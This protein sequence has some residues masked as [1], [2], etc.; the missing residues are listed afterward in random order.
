MNDTLSEEY[1]II[2]AVGKT[3]LPVNLN[4]T[5][6]EES[7][8]SPTSAEPVVSTEVSHSDLTQIYIL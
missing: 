5:R 7:N 4:D 8:T 6:D 3:D 1:K 2:S